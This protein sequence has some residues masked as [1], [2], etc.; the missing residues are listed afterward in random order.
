MPEQKIQGTAELV[1]IGYVGSQPWEL[2]TPPTRKVHY[3]S[4]MLLCHY[5]AMPCVAPPHK[6]LMT[7]LCS[8]LPGLSVGNM[9][10]VFSDDGIVVIHPVDC[11]VQRR[12]KP[13]EKIFMSYVSFCG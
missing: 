11:E 3:T 8:L 1:M 12:L 6:K 13:T 2:S 9:F 5:A 10:Y 7:T 4:A